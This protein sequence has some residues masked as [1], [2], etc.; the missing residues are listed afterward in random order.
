MVAEHAIDADLRQ[1]A[2]DC[3][4]CG[5]SKSDGHTCLSPTQWDF[6]NDERRFVALVSGRNCGKTYAALSRLAVLMTR[7]ENKGAR[8]LVWGPTYNQLKG[9]TLVAF[10]EY[11]HRLGFIRSGK[12]GNEP[13][14]EMIGDITVRF[15]NASN[16][17]QT[18]GHEYAFNWLDEAGQMDDDVFRLTNMATRQRRP[19]GSWYPRQMLIT[20]TPRGKNWIYRHFKDEGSP[21]FLGKN[22]SAHYETD[23]IEAIKYGIADPD[24]IA[25]GGYVEGTLEYDQEILGRYVSWGGNVFY[26]YEERRHY[27]RTYA[28]PAFDRVYGGI[29]V[30]YSGAATAITL[31]GMTAG[32][33]FVTFKEFY[34]RHCPQNVWM[35]IVEKWRDE[36]KVSRFYVDSAA[37]AEIATLKN[38]LGGGCIRPAMKANDAA[39]SAVGFINSLFASGRLTLMAVPNLKRE[40]EGYELKQQLSGDEQ[41]FLDKVKNGQPD[42]AIDSWRYHIGPLSA[43]KAQQ[44]YGKEIGFSIG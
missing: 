32:G 12:D 33:K 19:D 44:S 37:S 5:N 38:R 43:F 25:T 29:D 41:T 35:P 1:T 30:G 23:T 7:P 14:R 28:P 18:R 4:V 6:I 10:D 8:I 27:D 24:F 31:T 16:P 26:A 42:D 13:E 21:K 40:I 9:G 2:H 17:D 34:Q 15:R 22:L 3:K 39:G 11:F 20:T 36:F